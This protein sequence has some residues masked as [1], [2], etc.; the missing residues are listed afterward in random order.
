[1]PDMANTI[2]PT[3]R[4]HVPGR[5]PY[6]APKSNMAAPRCGETVIA[7]DHDCLIGSDLGFSMTQGEIC[8]SDFL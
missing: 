4:L 5:G 2:F 1:M 7:Y 8:F 6:V 3:K